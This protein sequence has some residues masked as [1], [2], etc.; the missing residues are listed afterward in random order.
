MAA[1]FRNLP[2]FTVLLMLAGAAMIAPAT[3]ALSLEDFA[4]A[5]DFFYT[6]VMIL[7]VAGVLGFATQA[8]SR[9]VTERGHLVTLVLAYL[10]VPL[11]LA[12]PMHQAVG[13]TR[14]INVYFRYGLGHDDD[15]G[16][17]V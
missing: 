10:W 12:L 11:I 2:L 13:N 4:T 7:V 16:G 14:F 8:P 6:A 3:L 5:R 15:W 9:N 1:Y 17:G